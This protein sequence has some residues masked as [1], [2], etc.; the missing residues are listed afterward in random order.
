MRLLIYIGIAV[1]VLAVFFLSVIPWLASPPKE[2]E[3]LLW[4]GDQA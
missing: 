4:E 1:I 2:R 3:P